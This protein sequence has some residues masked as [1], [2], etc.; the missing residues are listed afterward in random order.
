MLC[1]GVD[2]EESVRWW[3]LVAIRRC[4]TWAHSLLIGHVGASTIGRRLRNKR[5]IDFL[6][7][8]SP[9]VI[10]MLDDDTSPQLEGVS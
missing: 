6:R 4:T 8:G 2:G 9:T 5:N 3:R 7:G 10:D 1:Q